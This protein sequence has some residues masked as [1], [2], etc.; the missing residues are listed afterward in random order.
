MYIVKTFVFNGV[1]NVHLFNENDITYTKILMG[2]EIPI[3]NIMNN[4]NRFKLMN[5]DNTIYIDITVDEDDQGYFNGIILNKNKEITSP[6]FSISPFN[7]NIYH[8]D[9]FNHPISKKEVTTEFIPEEISIQKDI[10]T[11]TIV[12]KEE[13]VA[14]STVRPS[15]LNDR[16]EQL[17]KAI[18]VPSKST[19]DI[20]KRLEE[21]KKSTNV[22]SYA[23]IAKQGISEEDK[24]VEQQHSEIIE[25]VPSIEILHKYERCQEIFKTF[26]KDVVLKSQYDSDSFKQYLIKNK[27]F[28]Y[29]PL[30]EYNRAVVDFYNDIKNNPKDGSF[31]TEPFFEWASYYV[32]KNYPRHGVIFGEY[33]GKGYEN[34]KFIVYD[35][36]KRRN[37]CYP[38]LA[39]EES[40]YESEK[41]R[42]VQI[43]S[44]YINELEDGFS[45]FEFKDI[46]GIAC[47]YDLLNLA[48]I[49]HGILNNLEE[50]TKRMVYINFK[51][52]YPDTPKV[53][54][55]NYYS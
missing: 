15:N 12:S 32:R 41:N 5:N 4:T 16:I 10:I 54:Y 35:I 11:E 51:I 48:D 24:P 23:S 19:S 26:I 31:P 39:R 49:K 44:S 3:N 22:V 14:S 34:R 28:D 25:F 43:I 17:K 18:K 45:P 53:M 40:F 55:N 13:T 27:F 6:K 20:N 46:P 21:I 42:A 7:A 29:I 36:S 1:I 38:K 2:I 30:L 9:L 37:S 50:E 33:S 8:I 47:M 52:Q